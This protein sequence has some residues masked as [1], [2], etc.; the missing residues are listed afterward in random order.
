MMGI[1]EDA[2]PLVISAM[3]IVDPA[4]IPIN[5]LARLHQRPCTQATE[6]TRFFAVQ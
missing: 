3:P 5:Q 4:L 2:R 1:T 6:T